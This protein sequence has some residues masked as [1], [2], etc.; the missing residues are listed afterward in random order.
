MKGMVALGDTCIIGGNFTGFV[1]K[2]IIVV[3][4]CIEPTMC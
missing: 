4:S 2:N 1:L 3:S